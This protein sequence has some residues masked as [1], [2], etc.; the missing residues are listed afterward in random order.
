MNN[1][2]NIYPVLS[3]LRHD[4]HAYGPNIENMDEVELTSKQA[5]PLLRLKVI[6]EPKAD[7]SEDNSPETPEERVSQILK[8]LKS[9][10]VKTIPDDVAGFNKTGIATLIK[11]LGWMPEADDANEA[12][13]Q[14][15]S[16]E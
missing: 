5:A 3:P 6:G 12:L 8:V 14:L 16:E 1:D 4:G 11:T 15:K 10:V 2:T 9:G 13:R 7:E